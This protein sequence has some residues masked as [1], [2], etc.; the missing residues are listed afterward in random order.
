MIIKIPPPASPYTQTPIEGK[1]VDF[2][3]PMAGGPTVAPDWTK[4][5][6]VLDL[7]EFPSIPDKLK[8]VYQSEG[9]PK[10][11]TLSVS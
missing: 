6:L 5:D 9:G 11:V 3:K 2:S 10:E 8:V 1:P 7:T 4:E